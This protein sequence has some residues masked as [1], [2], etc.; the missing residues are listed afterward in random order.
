MSKSL[1]PPFSLKTLF[2][3]LRFHWARELAG[4]GGQRPSKKK[5]SSLEVGVAGVEELKFIPKSGT[6]NLIYSG[7]T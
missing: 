1:Q 6:R 7:T 5:E 3:R 4:D 2:V